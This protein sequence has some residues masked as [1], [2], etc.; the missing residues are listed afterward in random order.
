MI[1]RAEKKIPGLSQ[2]IEYREFWS[3]RTVNRYALS[4][5]DASIGWALTPQQ[6]GPRRLG[7]K[8]PVKEFI[9]ERPLDAAGAGHYR[10]DGLRAAGCARHP[11]SGGRQRAVVGHRHRKG[12]A[13]LV[14]GSSPGNDKNALFIFSGQGIYIFAVEAAALRYFLALRHMS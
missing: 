12:C 6:V 11:L 13:R 10:G 3:P 5:E 14:S 2:H 8:T 4:G 9:P 7:Q 1:K